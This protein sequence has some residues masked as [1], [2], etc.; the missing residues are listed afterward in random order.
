MSMASDVGILLGMETEMDLVVSSE[1]QSS[2]HEGIWSDAF[3][4]G[5]W[6]CSLLLEAGTAMQ[7]CIGEGSPTVV[8][9]L[10]ATSMDVGIRDGTRA[11]VLMSVDDVSRSL[12]TGDD[13]DCAGESASFS[14]LH[15]CSST[16]HRPT[17]R[18]PRS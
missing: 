17:T 4:A 10:M 14:L 13:G 9:A 16:L 15:L 6:R 1:E 5:A 2:R 18:G 12:M 8:G 7:L 3:N 11:G